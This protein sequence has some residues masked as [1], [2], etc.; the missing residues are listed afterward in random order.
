MAKQI[1]TTVEIERAYIKDQI[2]YQKVRNKK[3][4]YFYTIYVGAVKNGKFAIALVYPFNYNATPWAS[5]KPYFD[6]S[7]GDGTETIIKDEYVD[8]FTFHYDKFKPYVSNSNVKDIKIFPVPEKSKKPGKKLLYH[9]YNIRPDGKFEANGAYSLKLTIESDEIVMPI[10]LDP[11]AIE[12][13]AGRFTNPSGMNIHL[14]YDETTFDNHDL[15]N[16]SKRFETAL[17]NCISSTAVALGG[18]Y[19]PNLI[20]KPTEEYRDDFS[21]V[22]K[23]GIYHPLDQKIIH[24]KNGTDGIDSDIIST[25]NTNAKTDIPDYKSPGSMSMYA[26]AGNNR[27]INKELLESIGTPNQHPIPIQAY[28]C[29]GSPNIESDYYLNMLKRSYGIKVNPLLTPALI[30]KGI[31]INNSIL[32]VAVITGN[33]TDNVVQTVMNPYRSICKIYPNSDGEYK[34]FSNIDSDEIWGVFL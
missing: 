12:S 25:I 33:N 16:R 30:N 19:P 3:T 20:G 15:Y 10:S 21:R 13:M 26:L 6:I 28:L 24:T 18:E 29:S 9:E 32:R 23:R 7:W 17:Y 22:F 34:L 2:T 14:P 4:T 31:H 1:D 27:F 8:M 11:D 5:E